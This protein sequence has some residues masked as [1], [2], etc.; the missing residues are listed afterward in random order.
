MK[1]I[2]GIGTILLVLCAVSWWIIPVEQRKYGLT[3]GNL[4]TDYTGLLP[5]K[6]ERVEQATSRE[7][8]QQL[9]RQAN[10]EGKKISIAGLQHSQ[11]GHT[12]FE[13]AIVLDMRSFNQVLAV[14]DVQKTVKV[15]AGATF[16]TIQQAIA[17]YGLALKVTQSQSIFTVGGSLSI[18]AHGRDIRN[19]SMASNVEE[20]TLLTPTGDMEVLKKGDDKLRYVLGGYGLFGVMLDVTLSLTEDELYTMETDHMTARDYEVYFR[21]VQQD[22][23]IAMHYARLSVAPASFLEELYTVNYRRIESD[24]ALPALADEQ[25]VKLRK[26]ALDLGRQGGGYEDLFWRIQ[27]GHADLQVGSIISRNNVMR[28]E[29]TFMEYTKPG[30]VE[31]LQEFFVPVEVFTDYVEALKDYMPANDR[32][33]AVKV[34]NI[35]VRYTARDELTQLNYA[36]NDMLALV[37][38][39][40]HG[41]TDAEIAKAT[42]FIRGW[43]DVTRAYGGTYYLPYYPYQTP[44]QFTAA[45]PNARE[46]ADMKARLDPNTVFVNYFY[47]NYIKGLTANEN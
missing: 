26:A 25:L 6:I 38:L 31:V 47:D 37:V 3:A 7:Q 8:L 46:F 24:E 35:T 12:F 21:N 30:K 41:V 11:G 1:K 22:A 2:M 27:S 17:P 23:D 36:T 4:A 29:S 32:G 45:Y 13:D 15:E 44:E 14:D 9:V 34:H 43:T 33:H 20:L 16:D 5:T 42:A 10:A 18:N 19:G 39:I 40:Q 28:A